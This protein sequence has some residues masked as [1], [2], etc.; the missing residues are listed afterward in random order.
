MCAQSYFQFVIF[1]PLSYYFK[2]TIGFDAKSSF[3]SRPLS[4][5]ISWYNKPGDITKEFWEN[6]IQFY[7]TFHGL[8]IT[9]CFTCPAKVCNVGR[10]AFPWIGN[11]K[12]LGNESLLVT[13][14]TLTF[15]YFR[16]HFSHV[17]LIDNRNGWTMEID[18]VAIILRTVRAR[19]SL[20][21]TNI[22]MLK[23]YM[24]FFDYLV[25]YYWF[26]IAS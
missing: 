16:F 6:A 19:K 4:R 17:E 20:L 2:E 10:V 14:I 8:K 22:I 3:E 7:G 18:L 11:W 23:I 25:T 9:N 21:Q 15:V 24:L 13:T 12:I 26:C 1:K 5:L